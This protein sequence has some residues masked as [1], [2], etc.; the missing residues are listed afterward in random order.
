M[1]RLRTNRAVPE[2]GKARELWARG[3]VYSSA[4]ICS[5]EEGPEGAEDAGAGAERHDFSPFLVG[6]P[7]TVVGDVELGEGRCGRGLSF[8]KLLNRWSRYRASEWKLR[9]D[10]SIGITLGLAPIG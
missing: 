5:L 4:G 7:R 8:E 9:L 1:H 10:K 2:S 3:G 6:A